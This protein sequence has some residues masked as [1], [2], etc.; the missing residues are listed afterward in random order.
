[1]RWVVA[2]PFGLNRRAGGAGG[3]GPEP[4]PKKKNGV[5][6]RCVGTA[7]WVQ[8]KLRL[9]NA[10]SNGSPAQ[11]STRG[12]IY[13]RLPASLSGGENLPTPGRCVSGSA[14]RLKRSKMF[15]EQLPASTALHLSR[16]PPVNKLLALHQISGYYSAPRRFETTTHTSSWRSKG[17]ATA[18]GEGA[19]CTGGRGGGV[20]VEATAAGRETSGKSETMSNSPGLSAVSTVSPLSDAIEAAALAAALERPWQQLG[21]LSSFGVDVDARRG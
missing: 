5:S 11:L 15:L 16:L 2:G 10:L 1:M 4:P 12:F 18:A 17:Q 19:C 6:E 8:K 7:E 13:F 3:V 9:N 14:L 20:Q 21:T